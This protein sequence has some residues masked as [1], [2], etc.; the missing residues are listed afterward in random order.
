LAVTLWLALTFVS[1]LHEAQQN[2]IGLGLT[3]A[4][5]L[6]GILFGN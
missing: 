3:T 5:T 2:D 6:Y 4:L 1:A